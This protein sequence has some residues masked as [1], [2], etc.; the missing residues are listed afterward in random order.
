MTGQPPR[1][2]QPGDRAPDFIL[3]AVNREG[4]VSLADF[5]GQNAILVGLF[6]GFDC[7]FCRRQIAQLGV[8]HGKLWA[9]GVE[10][11]AIIATP[12]A[13]AAFYLKYRPTP[14]ILLAD[15]NMATH[16][17]FGLP[18]AEVVLGAPGRGTAGPPMPGE[19]D[20]MEG[21]GTKP[22]VAH[23]NQLAGHFLID[24]TGIVRWAHVEGAQRVDGALHF[25][26]ERELL[27]AARSL[28]L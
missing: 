12:V 15:P 4:A 20:D 19:S 3:P 6:R 26:S 10:T 22:I 21:A 25:P 17:A 14:I 18:R 7:P 24:S 11:L 27:A 1:L 23:G 2:V 9:A 8:A 28:P 13:R 16:R 5:L